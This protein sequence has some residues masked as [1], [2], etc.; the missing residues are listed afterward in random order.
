MPRLT[1]YNKNSLIKKLKEK[2]EAME[3]NEV[4]D[5]KTFIRDLYGLSEDKE[6]GYFLNRT[7]DS[8]KTQLCKQEGYI[9]KG[10]RDG[11]LTRLK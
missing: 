3:I 8:L 1:F 11:Y 9:L 5:R 4:A 10:H 2:I 7:F 6:V